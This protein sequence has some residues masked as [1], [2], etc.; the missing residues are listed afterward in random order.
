MDW[1]F[2]MEYIP[3]DDELPTLEYPEDVPLLLF[4]V[5]VEQTIIQGYLE[6]GAD[7]GGKRPRDL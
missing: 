3:A 1:S 7:D 6:R 5:E 4:N 2:W